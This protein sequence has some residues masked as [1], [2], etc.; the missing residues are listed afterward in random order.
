MSYSNTSSFQPPPDE[1]QPL[2][3]G[4]PVF[5]RLSTGED[6][7]CIAWRPM[8]ES[9]NRILLE[10]PIKIFRE[11]KYEIRNESAIPNTEASTS[12]QSTKLER[13]IPL[14]S[15]DV[16]PIYLDH[17]ITIAPLI[18]LMA[19]VYMEWS[20][21]AYSPETAVP[22]NPN[23]TFDSSE[24]TD[25]DITELEALQLESESEEDRFDDEAPY[26]TDDYAVANTTSNVVS[27][28]ANTHTTVQAIPT[29]SDYMDP[30]ENKRAFF[31][32]VLQ[33]FKPKR[34]H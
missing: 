27:I 6:L 21:Y 16:Y 31:D 18:P 11:Q 15:A 2:Y 5:V 32:Y 25:R 19:N 22:K 1:F 8:G 4:M 24:I 13:W 3:S 33:N 7:L 20:E 28:S 23:T 30:D 17:V 29:I 9:D 12:A 10:R 34:T 14:S 26:D